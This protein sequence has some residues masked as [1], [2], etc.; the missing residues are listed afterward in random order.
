MTETQEIPAEI[1][2]EAQEIARAAR[3]LVRNSVDA[4]AVEE[5]LRDRILAALLARD[6][7]AR[8][9]CVEI[10]RRHEG[11]PCRPADGWTEDQASFYEAGELD[12]SYSIATA[13][14]ATNEGGDADA[15]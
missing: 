7:A 15:S 14:E 13:I 9:E 10:A 11:K 8:K 5:M 4:I 6:T 3:K 1:M 2:A 12:A